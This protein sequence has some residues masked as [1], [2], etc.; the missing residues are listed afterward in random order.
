MTTI[1]ENQYRI[2]TKRL[3]DKLKISV[4]YLGEFVKDIN[5]NNGVQKEKKQQWNVRIVITIYTMCI[6]L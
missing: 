6:R 3:E 1:D 5:F 2:I 4:Y